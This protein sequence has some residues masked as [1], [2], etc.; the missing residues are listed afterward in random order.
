MSATNAE[1]SA[2][3]S[4]ATRIALLSFVTQIVT[5]AS[6]ARPSF[7]FAWNECAGSSEASLLKTFACNTSSGQDVAVA[8]FIAPTA[9]DQFNSIE[10]CGPA[11]AAGAVFP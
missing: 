5:A 10:F 1:E 4:K 2:T 6:H 8:S 7:N 11:A 3:F 9:V